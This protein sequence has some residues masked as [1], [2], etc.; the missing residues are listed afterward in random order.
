MRR[1]LLLI[2][3]SMLVLCSCNIEVNPQGPVTESEESATEGNGINTEPLTTE[4]DPNSHAYSLA[5]GNVIYISEDSTF[6]ELEKKLEESG[7]FGDGSKSESIRI[8]MDGMDTEEISAGSSINGTKSYYF[9]SD[10]LYWSDGYYHICYYTV[11]SWETG[12]SWIDPY[13]KKTHN[14][15]IYSNYAMVEITSSA[16]YTVYI[17]EN[18]KT[19]YSAGKTIDISIP[20]ISSYPIHI[21]ID[22]PVESYLYISKKLITK[23]GTEYILYP[24]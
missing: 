15:S 5:N 16:S 10:L 8:D 17:E 7:Y 4:Q 6:E 12:P 24:N 22:I 9:P 18:N 3:C 20:N 1:L 11:S 23:Y 13:A 2:L 19:V 21:Y 14:T